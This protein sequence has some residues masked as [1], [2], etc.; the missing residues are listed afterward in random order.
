MTAVQ[1]IKKASSNLT[2]CIIEPADQLFRGAAYNS[3]SEKHLLNVIAG[4]MSG[5]SNDPAHFLN[6]VMEQEMFKSKDRELI[7]NSFLPRNLYGNY[8]V[9]IWD[10]AVK[11]A[12][13]KGI[14]INWLKNR[15]IQ[16]NYSSKIIKL[17]LDNKHTIECEK[18]IIATG[19]LLPRN[20]VLINSSVLQNINYFQNPWK[21]KAVKNK[22][23]NLPVL[24]IGNGL[25]MVD[26]VIGLRE[27][28]FHGTI[29]AISPNGFNVLPHRHNGMQYKGLEGEFKS[30]LTLHQLVTVINRHVK[31]VREIGVSAEPIVDAIRPK[32]QE[33]WKKL[34]AHEKQLFMSRLRHLWG[35]ARHRIPLH[36]H[37]KIQN[38]RIEG[39]LQVK[40]G[41]IIDINE[42][43]NVFEV[44]YW[45]KKKNETIEL[46]VS[47]IINCTGPET[48][49]SRVPDHFLHACLN[50]GVISQDILKL[51]IS[52]E[53]SSFK[54]RGQDGSLK[55]NLFTL[56][57]NL[58]GELW[59]STAVN[60]L[61]VQ[62]EKLAEQLLLIEE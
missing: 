50:E 1:L 31:S 53:T 22:P 55:H 21:L 58:K 3:Y 42:S 33:I 46:N 11:L 49:L 10:E 56:G 44:S 47:S 30:D 23:K 43:L 5:L 15:V 54:V 37:D 29:Y 25:T 34:E 17:H 51:G 59:E 39:E 32:V 19:N 35:V 41:K 2:I 40:S 61:R 36:I 28:G 4:K 12:E 38:M 14:E 8:L 7:S 27:Y 48:D 57:S 18:C 16:L 13:T 62:A 24:I 20:P 60:E 6:W 45:D 26:T 52:A 9:T